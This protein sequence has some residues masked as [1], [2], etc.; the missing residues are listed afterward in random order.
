MRRLPFLFALIAQAV[1]AD[2]TSLVLNSGSFATMTIPSVAAFSAEGNYNIS[3][4]IHTITFPGSQT[5]IGTI[6]RTRFF[7][8]PGNLLI[9]VND[10]DSQSSRGNSVTVDLTSH[11]DVIVRAQRF[12]TIFPVQDGSTGSQWLEVQDVFTGAIL[13]EA[14][15]VNIA[16]ACPVDTAANANVVGSGGGLGASGASFSLGWLKWST[17]TV[18]PGSPMPDE[19]TP[20][21]LGDWHFNNS[22]T[23]AGTAGYALTL[24]ETSPTYGATPARNPIVQLTRQYLHAGIPQVLTSAASAL[25]GGST[26]AYAWTQISGPTTVTWTGAATATPTVSNTVFGSY[27]FQLICTDSSLNQTQRVIEDGFVFTDA[28]DVVITGNAQV[29]AVLGPQK[30]FNSGPWDWGDDRQAAESALQIANN[31]SAAYGYIGGGFGTSPWNVQAPGTISVTNHS[32]TVTGDASTRFNSVSGCPPWIAIWYPDSSLPAGHGNRIMPVLSCA[33]DSSLTLDTVTGSSKGPWND[34]GSLNSIIGSGPTYSGWHY[35]FIDSTT[36][37]N[38]IANQSPNDFYDNVVALYSLYYRSG[39]VEYLSAA[40]SAADGHW[41]FALDSGRNFY[42]GES[43]GGFPRNRAVLGMWIRALDG[44]PDMYPGLE[45][46]A[47][48]GHA[49]HQ[50]TYPW[51]LDW[52]RYGD[53]R[54]TSYSLGEQTYCALLDPTAANAATCRGYI[55]D[56]M[57][58]GITPQASKNF[59]VAYFGNMF[60]GNSGTAYASW[61]SGGGSVAL[62]HGSSTVTLS[63]NVWSS[64]MFVVALNDGNPYPNVMAF[65][66]ATSTPASNADFFAGAYCPAYVDTTH[67]TLKDC[68]SGATVPWQGNDC[69]SCGWALGPPG[70]LGRQVGFGAQP[71]MLGMFGTVMNWVAQAMACTAPGVPS[72]CD[73]TVAANARKHHVQVANWM[74]NTAYNAS[75]KAVWYAAGFVNCPAD[76]IGCADAKTAAEARLDNAESMRAVMVSYAYN[77]DPALQAFGDILFNAMWAKPGWTAPVGFTGDAIYLTG[78]N[79]VYG[80]FVTG[81]IPLPKYFGILFG[82]GGNASWPAIRLTNLGHSRVGAF[83]GR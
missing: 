49:A 39:I 44:R 65:L 35:A 24:T 6:G 55:S 30:R 11:P 2:S 23:N 43:F 72:G 47:A 22:L 79:D 71:F 81:A 78:Y 21:D 42:F 38:L 48:Y 51:T 40:R 33:S 46:I 66:P 12:G 13:T 10:G 77:G 3:F 80:F 59:Y 5:N 20:A 9:G 31:T 18:K 64:G 70:S 54:E 52:G 67:V 26:L 34:Q 75:Y 19:S 53:Q 58:N 73:N 36:L 29:D 83:T 69:G 62:Q 50:S 37:G 16:T 61:V 28:N 14:C 8:A 63:G 56:M 1:W 4:R 27:T 41:I 17:V 57:T 76:T 60:G 7:L 82:I 45:L 15:A 74:K 68:A 32:A 25:D